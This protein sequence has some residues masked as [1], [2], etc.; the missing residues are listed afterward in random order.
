VRLLDSTRHQRWV[1]STPPLPPRLQ[2]NCIRVAPGPI[3]P[4]VHVCARRRQA[5][6]M[7]SL[8]VSLTLAP[9]VYSVDDKLRS[10]SGAQLS[11][12]AGK[13][14]L[15]HQRTHMHACAGACALRGL[16]LPLSSC[17][18]ALAC[19]GCLLKYWG[20]TRKKSYKDS[21]EM[22]GFCTPPL[23]AGCSELA[24]TVAGQLGDGYRGLG[25]RLGMDASTQLGKD[26]PVSRSTGA[27][28]AL[29]DSVPEC[30]YWIVHNTKGR[31]AWLR[32]AALG[33]AWL[34]LAALGCAWL[35]LAALGVAGCRRLRCS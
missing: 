2:S 8:L 12:L 24:P 33:C 22:H 5:G 26:A 20:L 21:F 16:V 17:A 10:S 19:A 31:R 27:C 30:Q 34:R 32:L 29:C 15:L 1:Y 25:K 35:R 13:A 11:D 9:K 23:H 18:L 28:S 14:S 3:D 4:R 6:A 7:F